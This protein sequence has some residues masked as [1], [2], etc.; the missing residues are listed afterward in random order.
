VGAALADPR[1]TVGL[2]AD[3]LHLDA[4]VVAL[5][6]R[7][8]GPGRVSAVTDAIAALG[9]PPGRYP[10]GT[11]EVTVDATSARLA[12]G[13]LAGSLLSLDR[14]VRNLLAFTGASVAEAV[15]SVTTTPARLLGLEATHG[16]VEVGRP[17][18]LTLLTAELEVAATFVGGRLAYARAGGG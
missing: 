14:A 16:V 7:V 2:I 18:N 3:G 13:R 1:V 5:V 9:R 6:W 15:G 4:S 17:A 11:V 10:L 8:A 12:D